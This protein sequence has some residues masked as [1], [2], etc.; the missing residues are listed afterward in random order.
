MFSKIR[1]ALSRLD[2]VRD[3]VMIVWRAAPAWTV[4]WAVIL[5]LLG[6]QPAITLHL[7][8]EVIDSL[9]ELV[10]QWD[11]A[12]MR[13]AILYISLFGGAT[14]FYYLANSILA[15][16]RTIQRE[17]VTDHISNLVFDQATSLDLRFFE[18][19]QYYDMLQRAQNDISSKP[20][21][22]LDQFGSLIRHTITLVPYVSD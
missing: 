14:F 19:K 4:I 21:N 6:I 18:T 7:L 13:D 16:A 1:T 2:Y 22:L 12:L 3:G 11:P 9:T 20:I 8:R 5:I 10:D 15:I 17:K